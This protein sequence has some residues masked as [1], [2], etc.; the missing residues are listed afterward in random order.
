MLLAN[1]PKIRLNLPRLI[2]ILEKLAPLSQET[3]IAVLQE[4]S[5]MWETLA[6]QSSSKEKLIQDKLNSEQ[7]RAFYTS[8]VSK[9]VDA[10]PLDEMYEISLQMAQ[11]CEDYWH[12]EFQAA[13]AGIIVSCNKPFVIAVS[14][15][16]SG[17]TW[18]QGLLAKYHCSKGKRVTL[19]EPNETLHV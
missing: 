12:C 15:T 18:I 4:D 8:E 3:I 1:V 9:Y 17:K 10:V 11:D 6:N 16:G 19:V 5:N 14:P 2:S 7:V 13:I